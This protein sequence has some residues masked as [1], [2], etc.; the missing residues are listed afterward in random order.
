MFSLCDNCWCRS[1][2]KLKC[3]LIKIENVECQYL[4]YLNTYSPLYIARNKLEIHLGIFLHIHK[5]PCIMYSNGHTRILA[6][7]HFIS[8]SNKRSIA[9]ANTFKSNHSISEHLTASHLYVLL[10]SFKCSFD[11][12][13][14]SA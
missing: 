14:G 1:C 5:I 6:H 4:E 2:K 11:R 12:H 8:H 10:R 13:V 3:Q 9:R 7:T